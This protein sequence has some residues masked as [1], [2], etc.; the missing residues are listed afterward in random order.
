MNTNQKMFN[1]HIGMPK[2]GTK[3]LQNHMFPEHPDI[4]FL[5]TYMNCAD[6]RPQQCRDTDVLEFM[7]ELLWKKFN[8]PNISKCRK[9]YKRWADHAA[10]EGKILLWSWESLMENNHDIQRIRA[11]NLK[12]V[13]GEARIT[14]CLRHPESLMK[15]LYIQ[16]LKRDNIQCRAKRGKGHRFESIERWMAKGWDRPGH[17]P[18]AHLEYAETLQIFADVFGKDSI[19]I[20]LFE[21]L[22]ENQD[23]FVRDFCGLIGIDVEQGIS[24]AQGQR[25][26][27]TW[28]QEQFDQLEAL[29]DSPL[30]ALR[31]RFSHKK[32]RAE[33]LGINP[34]KENRSGNKVRIDIAPEWIEK[35]EQKT[36]AGNRMIQ[37]QWGTPLEQYGYP[38]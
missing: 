21:Q 4:D 3:T 22:V 13:V 2:T 25:S 16:L 36:R 32:K 8:N 11:E 17:P 20:L 24:L 31:F 6:Q 30:Q 35:I 1:L 15:S 7:N 26:N 34:Q 29:N 14:A 12:K 27:V 37:E 18:R 38:I 9:L 33:M 23:Q 19:K 10:S 5:G 28:T